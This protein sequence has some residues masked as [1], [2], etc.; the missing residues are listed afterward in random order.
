MFTYRTITLVSRNINCNTITVDDFVRA[1]FSD[2]IEAE[3][4]YNELYVPEWTANQIKYF[5]SGLNNAR[6]NAIKYAEKK[7]KTQSKR[8]E[9]VEKTIKE[10]RDN[11]KMNNHYYNLGFFDFDINPGEMGISGN[12]VLSISEL[13]FDKLRR[14]FENIKDNE[15]FKKATGWILTYEAQDGSY[16]SSFRPQIKLILDD[17]TQKKMDKEAADLTDKVNSFYADVTYWGD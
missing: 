5:E 4:K 2:I 9:Y 12:C 17:E 8:D 10:F 13:T 16:C 1:M 7:W 11:Y 3:E 14:C 6:N 15:Y